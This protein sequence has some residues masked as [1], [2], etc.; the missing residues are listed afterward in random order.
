MTKSGRGCETSS[1]DAAEANGRLDGFVFEDRLGY[2]HAGKAYRIAVDGI[3]KTRSRPAVG[4][5][6]SQ[7][8]NRTE[9]FVS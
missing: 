5:V 4:K 3:S 6:Y 7:K 9:S 8:P 1:A 2:G